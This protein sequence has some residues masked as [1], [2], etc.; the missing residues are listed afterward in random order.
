MHFESLE[1]FYQT[2]EQRPK[3]PSDLLEFLQPADFYL[4]VK[5]HGLIE[6]IDLTATV[7]IC[8]GARPQTEEGYLFIP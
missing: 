3:T 2:H 4:K 7:V 8:K 5:L 6:I 1:A